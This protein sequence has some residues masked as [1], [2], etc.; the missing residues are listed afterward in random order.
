MSNLANNALP[1]KEG[2]RANEEINNATVRLI[3]ENGENIGVVATKEAIK[4]AY[5]AGLDLVE[6]SPNVDPPV[7][8]IIDYGKYKYEA[9]KKKA[10]AKKKQKVVNIKELKIRPL[11]EDHDYDVK[12]KA[13]KRFIEDGDKVK[14]TMRFRGREMAN[15]QLGKDILEKLK[16]DLSSVAKIETSPKLD[17]KQMMMVVAPK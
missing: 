9:Q 11:I 8:K 6:V 15:I 1:P 7:C 16:E 14:F 3:D 2:P 4:R 17:G 5:E 12:L 10:D 13:A